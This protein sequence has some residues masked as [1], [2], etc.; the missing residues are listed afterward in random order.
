MKLFVFK[1]EE[2]R[3][4]AIIDKEGKSGNVVR[5]ERLLTLSFSPTCISE[6]KDMAFVEQNSVYSF[7]QERENTVNVQYINKLKRRLVTYL[8]PL[9]SWHHL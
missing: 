3:L 5:A 9:G 2:N 1:P 6:Q 7:W 4:M 8:P